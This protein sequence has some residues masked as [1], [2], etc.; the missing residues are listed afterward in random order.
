MSWDKLERKL[1]YLSA[2]LIR[3]C[4]LLS[5]FKVL[6]KMCKENRFELNDLRHTIN[7][8]TY[9]SLLPSRLRLAWEH[10]NFLKDQLLFIWTSCNPLSRMV[11][12]ESSFHLITIQRNSG[13]AKPCSCKNGIRLSLV[14]SALSKKC[15]S[16]SY[17][18]FHSKYFGIASGFRWMLLLQL[19]IFKLIFGL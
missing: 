12:L 5:S 9:F 3:S 7:G 16:N 11:F 17:I 6:L 15:K 4:S 8:P 10:P 18:K 1:E 19:L 2:R 13:K 14:W